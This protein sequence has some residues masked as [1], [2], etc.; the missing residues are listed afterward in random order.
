MSRPELELFALADSR[1]QIAHIDLTQRGV[2][3]ILVDPS[4]YKHRKIFTA[5][6]IAEAYEVRVLQSEPQPQSRI[7]SPPKIEEISAETDSC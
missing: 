5:E 2:D 3:A 4:R 1:H 7:P 6:N